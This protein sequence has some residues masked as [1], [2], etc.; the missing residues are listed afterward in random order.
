MNKH[1]LTY[2]IT[3]VFG[4]RIITMSY[5]GNPHLPESHLFIAKIDTNG[6]MK[7][8]GSYSYLEII[9]MI[10]ANPEFLFFIL[11]K[12]GTMPF[13]LANE[14]QKDNKESWQWYL[15]TP[16]K[17]KGFGGT[18]ADLNHFK[19]SP[20]ICSSAIHYV[21]QT[22]DNI[23]PLRDY[24][25]KRNLV[26]VKEDLS[27]QLPLVK[28]NNEVFHVEFEKLKLEQDEKIFRLKELKLQ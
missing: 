13:G 12:N 6:K 27:F 21:K 18:I 14:I 4:N 25:E 1:L 26:E 15:G 2:A 11:T 16:T 8:F 10:R 7:Q 22:T 17:L 9:E 3:I 24:M 20:E 5:Q 23:F 28:Y 19:I